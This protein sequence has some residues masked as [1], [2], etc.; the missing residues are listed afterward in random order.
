MK[1]NCRYSRRNFFKILLFSLIGTIM[2]F[3]KK[4]KFYQN[5]KKKEIFWILNNS[6]F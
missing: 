4:K 6:D 5:T 3:D 1:K 2:L